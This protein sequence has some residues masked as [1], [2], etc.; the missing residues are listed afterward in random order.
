MHSVFRL[1]PHHGLRAV[2]DVGR[3][4]LAAVG[5]QAMHEQGVGLG[6]GH[7]VAVHAPV[8]EGGPARLVLGLVAHAGPDVGGDEV[9]PL[10]GVARMFED[11]VAARILHAGHGGIDLIAAGCADMHGEAEDLGRLQPGVGHVV[12]IAHPGHDAALEAVHVDGA[13]PVHAA[14]LDEGEQ[15]G[16]DLAG[17]VFVGQAVDDR[18]ARVR[19]EALDLALLE[20]ADHHQVDHAADDAG[21]VLHRLGPAE[22][23]V[24]RGE[25]DDRAA[26]LV[27][28]GLETHTG[29]RGCLLEDH[30][31]RAVLQRLVLLVVLEAALD[32]GGAVEQVGVFLG[33]Q[34]LELQVMAHQSVTRLHGLGC[35]SKAFTRGTRRA[36]ISRASSWLRIS[37][38]TRRTTRSAVTLNSR[39]ASRPWASRAPHGRSSSMPSIRPWPRIST[40]P[41]TPA[42]A[43]AR[44]ALSAA[45]TLAALSS[46]PSSCMIF[47]VS[48]PAR[49]ASGLP[50]KVV[51]WLPALSTPAARGPQ[52]TAPT[53]TP[54]PKPLA[55]GITSG[56]MPAHWWA[57]HLPVRPMPHCTSSSISNRSCASQTRRR[58]CRNSMRAGLMPP[59]PWMVSRKTAVM[60]GCA[61]MAASTA[62]MSFS[63]TRTK[64]GTSG[65]KPAWILGLA[66]ADSVAIE[67]PWNAPS[68]TSTSGAVLPRS[69]PNLRAIFSAASLA[70]RPLLQKK[71][72]V[73]PDSSQSLLAS[74]SCKGTW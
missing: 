30:G 54:E 31:Q 4:F 6:A 9:R 65:P 26:H 32:D 20:G 74:S 42:S 55:R 61:A 21:R 56:W 1:V 3:H 67:R 18:H 63:G 43:S 60:L 29:A 40:T 22:L 71:T 37:G 27:H 58:A 23:A 59:S 28:A 51:P 68:N 38:G 44:P 50:P 64:P 15:I 36:T 34:V 53:G 62:A 19:R 57:N 13:A 24:A 52:T 16:K 12:A 39:P 72:L 66:V 70:S 73:R 17:V 46:R 48:M 5:R 14:V 2:D 35:A 11:A 10:A 47:S 8:R 25:M 33:A 41:A 7:H 49:I 45:P 69:W